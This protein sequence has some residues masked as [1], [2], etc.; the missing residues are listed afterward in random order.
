MLPTFNIVTMISGLVS[1]IL[2]LIIN[3]S[4]KSI[5]CPQ[6]VNYINTY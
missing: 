3:V 2:N 1:S 4:L 5:I 6:K